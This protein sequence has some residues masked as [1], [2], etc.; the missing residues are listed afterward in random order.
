MKTTQIEPK[1]R[2]SIDQDHSEIS[3]N[4]KHFMVTQVKGS[5][6]TFDATIYTTLNDFKT[7]EIDLWIDPCS[8]DTGDEKRDEHLKSVDF[9]DAYNNKQI[10]FI[11]NKI[12]DPDPE[13]N[14][15]LSGNL[16][17]R[18]ITKDVKLIVQFG[19]D[20]KDPWGNKKP[21]FSVTGKINRSDWGLVWNAPME[22]GGFMISD[23]VT[24]LCELKL[25]N[26]SQNDLKKELE[27][28]AGKKNF[29]FT[30]SYN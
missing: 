15:E 23:E 19:G 1:T 14:H 2:W 7:A 8:I 17:M 6:K 29:P 12:G 21:G 20:I 28:M 13:G 16:T 5:F 25:I 27:T 9:F 26:K 11:S 18:G 3:F 4:V 24:I 30:P 10:T 22:T